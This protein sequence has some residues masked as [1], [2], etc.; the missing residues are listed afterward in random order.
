[1]TVDRE[2]LIADRAK[3]F[4]P[5]RH[6][7]VRGVAMIA[8]AALV[9]GG[10]YIGWQ[11]AGSLATAVPRVA[12]PA[13]TEGPS[14]TPSPTRPLFANLPQAPVSN[15]PTALERQIEALSSAIV[16]LDT[17][18]TEIGAEQTAPVDMS[19]EITALQESNKT[20]AK[21]FR[22]ILEEEAT[23]REA[24]RERQAAME[25]ELFVLRERE[26]THLDEDAR[27][28]AGHRRELERLRLEH[29][30]TAKEQL[31]Q[32]RLDAARAA[33]EH[34]Q[35]KELKVIE[36]RETERL[37][38]DAER[39]KQVQQDKETARE[40]VEAERARRISGGI[41]IDDTPDVIAALSNDTE[42]GRLSAASIQSNA[43]L[44]TISEGTLISGVLE[45]AIQ[46]D[47]PGAIRAVVSEPVWS[48]DASRILIP[49]G[50]RLIGRYESEIVQGQSRVL[51]AWSR[52]KLP[53]GHSI[54]LDALGTDG[55]GR[56]GLGGHVDG[57][58]T[59]TFE[60]AF[61]ISAVSAISNLG[62]RDALPNEVANAVVSEGSAIAG[63]AVRDALGGYLAVPP[64][65]HVDQGT[66]ITV[67]VQRDLLI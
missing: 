25:D 42:A 40:V 39:E 5:R 51:I 44:T 35:R 54:S 7:E 55:L 43:P 8:I 22:A 17:R 3:L 46:S 18:I 34:E 56:A 66:P 16:A 27:A 1:M 64:T 29:E 19:V 6:S 67:F 4:Q 61:L 41:A 65:I 50:S 59:T 63:E 38:Q 60:A 37:R 52:A 2:K 47:L 32:H 20:L 49:K 53:D 13:A 31:E 11:N 48:E 23:N 12:I 15:E 30:L 45:T 24:E 10:G 62:G 9:M 14:A 36:A 26:N 33:R 21:E 57:H 58:F 28:E